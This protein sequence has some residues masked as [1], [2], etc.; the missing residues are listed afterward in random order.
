MK[1][2]FNLGLSAL[3]FPVGSVFAEVLYKDAAQYT[4]LIS[5]M[6]IQNTTTSPTGARVH[7]TLSNS[8]EVLYEF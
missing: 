6:V 3:L 5:P 1:L 4:S 7:T 2:L 8:G